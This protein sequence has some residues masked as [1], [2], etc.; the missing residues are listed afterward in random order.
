MPEPTEWCL[1]ETIS[2]C[3]K[4]VK[5]EIFT[6][7]RA[8]FQETPQPS[9][10]WY[11]EYNTLDS[12][13]KNYFLCISGPTLSVYRDSQTQ[14]KS[15][16]SISRLTTCPLRLSFTCNADSNGTPAD[17]SCACWTFMNTKERHPMVCVG[18]KDGTIT[19]I[20]I[21]TQTVR[22]MRGHGGDVHSISAHPK[23]PGIIVS[24]SQDHSVRLWNCITGTCLARYHGIFG[25]SQQVHDVAW[26]D[27][28]DAFISCDY[29]RKI[30][31]WKLSERVLDNI[32][33]SYYY[34][35][36]QRVRKD[37]PGVSIPEG[38]PG[39][40]KIYNEYFV[41]ASDALTNNSAD[42]LAVAS[43]DTIVLRALTYDKSRCSA[44]SS[45]ISASLCI[46]AVLPSSTDIGKNIFRILH[47]YPIPT[48]D[49]SL[50][51][52]VYKERRLNPD[53]ALSFC[54]IALSR[55]HKL[56]AAGNEH[57]DTFIW[58]L[59]PTTP[60]QHLRYLPPSSRIS[61][62][63]YPPAT[64]RPGDDLRE[65]PDPAPVTIR[66]MGQVPIAEADRPILLPPPEVGVGA[67]RSLSFHPSRLRLVVGYD[68][69]KIAKFEFNTT[70]GHA[71]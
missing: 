54:R 57:G 71:N 6:P 35:E 25:N 38:L 23:Y 39:R 55:T 36:R 49:A 4:D 8:T 11:L 65:D 31:L 9:P 58:P 60:V 64:T 43:N 40:M 44:T 12:R 33:N 30:K 46:C 16:G 41:A 63:W 68:C 70:A 42:S 66:L 51:D 14:E 1:V 37:M 28:G 3:K 21:E 5:H 67:V 61:E 26:M 19:S 15:G 24:G 20:D 29:D 27:Y 69:G 48:R 22:F 18:G 53:L 59:D 17:M 56:L 47:K 13:Y 10:V 2:D 50:D 34:T 7:K 45:A 62:S 32:F 52:Q